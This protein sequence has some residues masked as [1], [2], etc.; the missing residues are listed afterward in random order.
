MTAT[1]ARKYIVVFTPPCPA[2]D[3][4]DA[5]IVDQDS[6]ERWEAGELIQDAFPDLPVSKAEQLVS[7]F[8]SDCWDRLFGT[9]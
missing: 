9:R 3:S 4:N 8:H 5:M 7:G 6:F 2:C 1:K